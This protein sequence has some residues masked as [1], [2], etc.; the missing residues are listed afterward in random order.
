[1]LAKHVKLPHTVSQQEVSD[2]E[3][4]VYPLVFYQQIV[5]KRPWR[6]IPEKE[7][8][9]ELLAHWDCRWLSDHTA[10]I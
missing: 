3:V 6:A 10:Q 9:T 4:E 7:L 2:L 8:P 1:M 5:I